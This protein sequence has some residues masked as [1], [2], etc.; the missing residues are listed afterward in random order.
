MP[1]MVCVARF[2]TLHLACQSPL[3][4]APSTPLH[5]LVNFG[6]GA[7]V[8]NPVLITLSPKT[9]AFFFTVTSEYTK[10]DHDDK[11]RTSDAPEDS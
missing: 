10:G 3:I 7:I 9:V 2:M 11:Y 5:S 8:V 4:S 1:H 6:R